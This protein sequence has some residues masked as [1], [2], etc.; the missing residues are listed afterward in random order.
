MKFLG[1][2]FL[3]LVFILLF[4][5]FLF[6]TSFKFQFL[7]PEF[8]ISSFRAGGVYPKLESVLKNTIELQVKQGKAS[9]QEARVWTGVLSSGTLQ[10]F[11]EKNLKLSLDFATGKSKEQ[12]FYIPFEKLPKGLVPAELSG[13]LGNEIS[14]EQLSKLLG[15][16][17]GQTQIQ[18]QNLSRAGT[19][20]LVSWIVSL[21]VLLGVLLIM[22]LVTDEGKRLTAPGVGLILSS[23]ATLAISAFG[24]LWSGGAAKEMIGNTAEP[25]AQLLGTLGPP[26]V[27]PMF[28][29]WRNIAMA[30]LVLGIVLLFV[31]KP[32][33]SLKKAKAKK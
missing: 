6:S 8:W 32:V 23:L 27:V 7:S 18:N 4:I 11:I 22:Y 24:T 10:D 28:A 30:T 3:V 33:A 9:A 13:T 5:P 31:K 29:L 14:P 1:K 12:K 2:A 19:N 16:Q 21:V 20:A 17:G 26:I 15:P 25:A